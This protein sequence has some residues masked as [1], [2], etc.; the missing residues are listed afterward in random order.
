MSIRAAELVVR[1]AEEAFPDWN[2][3][4][5]RPPAL[6]IVA[7]VRLCLCWLRRN[8]TFAELGDDFGIATSTA[9]YYATGMAEFLAD[10]L[11]CPAEELADQVAGKVCLVDGSLVPTFN[12]R[13]RTDLYS[14][15]HR[16]HGMNVQ[17][18]VDVHGRLIATST[19]YPG[20]RHDSWCFQQAGFAHLLTGAGGGV[21]DAGY[22]G[23]E[24]VTPIKKKPGVP[25]AES[26]TEFN[27]AIAKTRVGAEWGFAHLKNWRILASRYRSDLSR[28][29]TV[30]Q[31]V[32]GLQIINEH[33]SDRR[34][35][36]ARLAA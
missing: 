3:K 27:T 7:A 12:W 25:R 35:T 33:C 11:G 31:A 13:H 1:L 6:D 17:A 5:G 14:G 4:V 15:K 2:P 24:L 8:M 34:L 20:S 9:W 22:Q 29:D 28:I 36:F 26:D 23:C 19:A 18:I 30:I 21:G 32:T 10:T 16:K